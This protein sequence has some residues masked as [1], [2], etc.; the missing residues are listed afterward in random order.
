ML[1]SNEVLC[2]IFD[3][4]LIRTVK[5]SAVNPET[6]KYYLLQNWCY[7]FVH[8]C[9][10]FD[11]KIKFIVFETQCISVC[12]SPRCLPTIATH[13]YR[14]WAF[15][16]NMVHKFF[17]WTKT[18]LCQPHFSTFSCYGLVVL[19]QFFVVNFFHILVSLLSID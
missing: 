17:L 2:R 10:N 13:V 11:H 3:T 18:E 5:R 12:S 9:P 19:I 7:F 8:I 1:S 4:K 15:C 6:A 16:A 14:L